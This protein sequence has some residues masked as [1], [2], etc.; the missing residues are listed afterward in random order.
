MDG[1]GLGAGDAD[2]A[3]DGEVVGDADATG[4][5]DEDADRDADGEARVPG[6][7]NVCTA[8]RMS[9]A[10]YGPGEDAAGDVGAATCGPG[11]TGADDAGSAEEAGI[12]AA[13]GCNR[14]ADGCRAPPDRAK[15]TAADA[16]RTLAATTGGVRSGPDGATA[17]GRELVRQTRTLPPRQRGPR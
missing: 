15:L 14:G 17:P 10:G 1:D 6:D 7:V 4:D 5:V 9:G 13:V 2:P 3:G 16:A 12:A 11:N 8:G